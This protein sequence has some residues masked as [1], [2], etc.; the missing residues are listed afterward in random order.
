MQYIPT[1]TDTGD[2]KLPD[3]IKDI[4]EETAADIHAVWAQGRVSEGWHYGKKYDLE[5][6]TH[7]SLVPYEELPESEKDYDRN[8][9]TQTFKYIL[10]KGFCISREGGDPQ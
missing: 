9:V 1:P 5:K 6:K 8:T 4:I 7:P 10:K 2:I 3:E